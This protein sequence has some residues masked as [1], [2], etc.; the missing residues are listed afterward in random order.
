MADS[1]GH[2]LQTTMNTK[3]KAW[4]VWGIIITSVL[5]LM[6]CAGGESAT[7]YQNP[8]AITSTALRTTVEAAQVDAYQDG[9]KAQH[10]LDAVHAMQTATAIAERQTA[11]AVAAQ[12]T[13]TAGAI[14]ATASAKAARATATQGAANANAT[15]TAW[16]TT[17]EAQQA[18]ATA[19]ARA[20]QD[21]A[22][23]TAQAASAQTTATA[24]AVRATSTAHTA[25]SNATATVEMGLFQ[26]H[27]TATKG[28]ANAIATAQAAQAEQEKLRA[29]RQRML[30]PLTTY[31]PWA[32][33]VVALGFVGW[34]AYRLLR[35]FEDRKRV[36]ETPTGQILVVRGSRVA[37]PT[38][39]WAPMMDMDE[40]PALAAAHHEQD[41]VTRRD[42]IT[43]AIRATHPPVNSGGGGT[44]STARRRWDATQL[45][46][47]HTSSRPQTRS[48]RSAPGIGRV[49]VLKRIDH[50]IK[51]GIIPPNLARAIE[52]D[53]RRQV[54][55]GEYR[56]L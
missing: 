11:T 15:A 56:E 17:V 31:G 24:Q 30:Q 45:L 9:I 27:A 26:I 55:D 50:A 5:T 28:A 38:R 3:K 7:T 34:G 35:T 53:W 51:G 23:A 8:P 14:Q 44:T 40:R 37:M 4:I 21:A 52:Q 33:L 49:V 12:Q 29:D 54:V 22:T 48:F 20:Q 6:A 1:A 32:L 42:Q 43:S 47:Q 16:Q 13:A 41:D 39:N 19:T 10:T 36:V 18:M 2:I 46:Q 25:A